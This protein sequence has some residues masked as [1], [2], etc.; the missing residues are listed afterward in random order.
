MPSSSSSGSSDRG[1]VAPVTDDLE[2]RFA[3]LMT[4]RANAPFGDTDLVSGRIMQPFSRA[5]HQAASNL[6]QK[7]IR[8]VQAD[9]PDRGRRYVERAAR[10]PFDRHEEQHPLAGEAHMMLYNLV[11]DELEDA[12]ENDSGWLDAALEVLAASDHAVSCEVRDVLTVVDKEYNITARERSTLRAA[13]AD[14]PPRAELRDLAVDA[15]DLVEIVMS[16][17]DARIAYVAAARST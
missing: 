12:A 5:S 1:S 13:V 15:D 7:A 10:L 6:L 17:I 3:R 14:V 8:A 11:I 16:L 2:E 4:E 9:D